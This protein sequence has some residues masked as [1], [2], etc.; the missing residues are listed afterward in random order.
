[1]DVSK[2]KNTILFRG[3][4]EPGGRDERHG[5]TGILHAD[6]N[7]VRSGRLPFEIGQVQVLLHDERRR[8]VKERLSCELMA[9]PVRADDAEEQAV[10]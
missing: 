6:D 7:G 2:I 5:V 9:V 4:S 3:M 8:A 10:F 1:M